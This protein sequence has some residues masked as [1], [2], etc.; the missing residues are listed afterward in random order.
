MHL[1]RSF[2]EESSQTK[3]H[4]LERSRH[5]GQQNRSLEESDVVLW[6]VF[7]IIHVPRLEDW[8]VMPVEHIGFTLMPHG[9][10]NCSPAVDVPPNP[11]CEMD[12][13]DSEVKEVVAP[14]PLQT[15][16]LSKL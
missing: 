9:F 12:T 16:L 14:K 4:A 10:F 13:K 2:Q 8:P 11:A 7:G 6:Y 1:T 5:M 3:T 15:G